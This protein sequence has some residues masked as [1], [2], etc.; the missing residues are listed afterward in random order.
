VPYAQLRTASCGSQRIVRAHE[1]PWSL[2]LQQARQRQEVRPRRTD[3][4]L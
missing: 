3:Q 2:A 1:I 4:Q